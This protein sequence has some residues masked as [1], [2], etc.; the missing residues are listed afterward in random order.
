VKFSKTIY[1]I[2]QDSNIMTA[3]GNAAQE[4]IDLQVQRDILNKA[5]LLTKDSKDGKY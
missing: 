5:I 3:A 4:E 1:E 2:F